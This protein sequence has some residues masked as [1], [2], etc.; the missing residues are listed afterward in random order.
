MGASS[1]V[2]HCWGSTDA[3]VQANLKLWAEGLVGPMR[4][5]GFKQLTQFA[6][7]DELGYNFA[8][9]GVG[10]H[11]GTNNITHNPRVFARFHSYLK[12]M[13]GLTTPQDFGAQSW[14]EVVPLT[15]GNLTAAVAGSAVSAEVKE[16]LRI[17]YYWTMRFVAWDV[18]TWYAKATAALVAANGGESFSIYTNWNNVRLFRF[19]GKSLLLATALPLLPCWRGIL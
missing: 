15:R 17:R 11:S 13:S 10:P 4:S 12:N 7:H 9:V 6:L 14:S 1:D 19:C 5:A 8:M 18:E 3:E 2:G 16:G